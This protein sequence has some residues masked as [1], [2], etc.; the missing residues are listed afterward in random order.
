ME[1]TLAKKGWHLTSNGLQR[2][3]DGLPIGNADAVIKN[4]LNIDLRHI[5][6]KF[7]PADINKGK[8]DALQGPCVLQVLK[9]RNIAAPKINEGSTFAPRMIKVSLTDG[10]TTC[11]ALE[12]EPIPKISVE[13]AP[14]TK[15]HLSGSIPMHR[16][17][18]LLNGGNTKCLGGKVEELYSKWQVA[19]SLATHSRSTRQD[20]GPPPWVEFGQGVQMGVQRMGGRRGDLKK[21]LESQ[22]EH[23]ELD[24]EFEEQRKATI[25]ELTKNK[26]DKSLGVGKVNTADRGRQKENRN[27]GPVDRNNR[28]SGGKFQKPKHEGVYRELNY[29]PNLVNDKDVR[30]LVDMGF[31]KDVSTTALKAHNGNFDEA[32]DSLILESSFGS[33]GPRQGRQS[34]SSN[35]KTE[36][37]RGGRDEDHNRRDD[38]S[39]RD[40]D[41]RWKD[42][43]TRRKDSDTRRNGDE[44]RRRERDDVKKG[45]RRNRNEEEEE[46]GGSRPSGP[47]TLFDFLATKLGGET[48]STEKSK[49]T[50]KIN[51]DY[52]Q[53]ASVKEAGITFQHRTSRRQTDDGGNGREDDHKGG[54]RTGA[55]D[56]RNKNWQ[57]N[58]PPRFRKDQSNSLPS[59]SRSSHH[60][61]DHEDD[62]HYADY[63]RTSYNNGGHRS[64]RH[65]N[66]NKQSDHE[67]SNS[68]RQRNYEKRSKFKDQRSYDSSRKHER[69]ASYNGDDYYDRSSNHPRQRHYRNE[70]QDGQNKNWNTYNQGGEGELNSPTAQTALV[71]EQPSQPITMVQPQMVAVFQWKPGDSCL[72]M[73]NDGVFYPAIIQNIDPTGQNFVVYYE[74]Y[75][76]YANIQVGDL[77]PYLGQW[78]TQLMYSN[79]MSQPAPAQVMDSYQGPLSGTLEVR[80]GGQGLKRFNVPPREKRGARPSAQVYTPPSGRS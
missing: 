80:R 33:N 76:D 57:D 30:K 19:K 13:T 34:W 41:N 9:V 18:L 43:D 78:T 28:E 72:A 29:K 36:Y 42:N 40:N 66:Y 3:K 8:M 6:D 23:T 47:S 55:R 32:L 74:D 12:V 45:G 79:S 69:P 31:T 24:K 38:F 10:H 53:P 25:Q 62:R 16:G 52:E 50:R 22:R 65:G 35:G 21:S 51:S 59:S 73:W 61:Y 54:Q 46:D 49:P 27:S 56:S 11:T 17:F 1:N 64:H 60:D 68:D 58:L 44:Y 71:Y 7:L 2:C 77:R 14:G 5:G 48:N 67:H 75:G 20:G 39:R 4:A 63:D 26:Q 37:R 70:G 15:L